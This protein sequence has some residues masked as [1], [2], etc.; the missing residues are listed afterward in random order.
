[1]RVKA[2]RIGVQSSAPCA[3]ITSCRDSQRDLILVIHLQ[4]PDRG[5]AHGS[6][7]DDSSILKPESATVAGQRHSIRSARLRAPAP[8]AEGLRT[9]GPGESLTRFPTQEG[10]HRVGGHHALKFTVFIRSNAAFSVPFRQFVIARLVTCRR[11]ESGHC[12]KKFDAQ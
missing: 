9:S 6:D 2:I 1:M 10:E 3:P 4:Q 11:F 5:A 8:A 7:S 12:L